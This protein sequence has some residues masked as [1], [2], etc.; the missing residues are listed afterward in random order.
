MFS[1]GED[2]QGPQA[3]QP[4]NRQKR[5]LGSRVDMTQI[6]KG[7][8][9]D[10]RLRG[11]QGIRRFWEK[12]RLTCFL[13]QRLWK[14]GRNVLL[15]QIPDGLNVLILMHLWD[16]SS[17]RELQD[18]STHTSAHHRRVWPGGRNMDVLNTRVIAETRVCARYP[19]GVQATHTW[20][21]D[22][23]THDPFCLLVLSY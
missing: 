8:P 4:E 12:L 7:F 19:R 20:S 10:G 15:G 23:R 17:Q 3:K 1:P 18:R 16:P 2:R 6:W 5:Y 13:T 9:G 14:V 22:S 21:L 11:Q